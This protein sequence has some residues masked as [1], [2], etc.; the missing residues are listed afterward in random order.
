MLIQG[1][2]TSS[3]ETLTVSS[4]TSTVTA[5]LAGAGNIHGVLVQVLTGS[6]YYS[7]HGAGTPDSGDFYAAQYDFI[8]ISPANK[9]RMLRAT[10]TDATVKVQAFE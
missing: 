3:E 7:L 1:V 2:P 10:G 5:D 8:A 4:T 9:L 6:I